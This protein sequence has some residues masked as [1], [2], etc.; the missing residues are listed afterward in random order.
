MI[1][2]DAVKNLLSDGRAVDQPK[3]RKELQLAL[4]RAVAYVTKLAGN[5]SIEK[6]LIGMTVEESQNRSAPLPAHLPACEPLLSL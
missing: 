1:A 2:I 6:R 4:Q 5:L 3:P